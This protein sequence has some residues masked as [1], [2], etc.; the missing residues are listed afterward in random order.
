[1]LALLISNSSK[2]VGLSGNTTQPFDFPGRNF[3]AIAGYGMISDW[4]AA[5][6][7]ETHALPDADLAEMS[8]DNSPRASA[9]A[10]AAI[11]RNACWLCR[12][13]TFR[14]SLASYVASAEGSFW[15]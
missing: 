8:S 12:T 1:M 13:G 5:T 6:C 15:A 11:D 10:M 2:I 3:S 4:D 7:I 14:T 9:R